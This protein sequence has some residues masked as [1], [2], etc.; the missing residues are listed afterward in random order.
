MNGCGD[1][2]VWETDLEIKVLVV[3]DLPAVPGVHEATEQLVNRVHLLLQLWWVLW[4]R[5]GVMYV[6]GSV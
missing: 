3:E 4:W 5:M 1:G 6:N 2:L